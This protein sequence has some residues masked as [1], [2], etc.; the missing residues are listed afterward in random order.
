[1]QVP[2]QLNKIIK[3]PKGQ[4]IQFYGQINYSIWGKLLRFIF[5][6]P[7]L[8]C[9]VNYEN[10]STQSFRMVNQI[11]KGGILINKKVTNHRELFD[12]F[13][14]SGAKNQNISSLEFYSNLEWGFQK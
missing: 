11:L 5:Q 3:I 12:Y 14:S 13:S 7:Y 1:M 2:I 9:K 8:Y 10:G 4:C 6:P